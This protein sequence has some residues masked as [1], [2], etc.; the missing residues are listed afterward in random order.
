MDGVNPLLLTAAALILVGLGLV[1]GGIKL[2][3]EGGC[4]LWCLGVALGATGLVLVLLEG[5]GFL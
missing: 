5:L 4:V 3:D 2:E 1:W